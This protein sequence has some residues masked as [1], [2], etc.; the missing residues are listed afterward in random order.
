VKGRGQEGVRV[1]DAGR[2]EEEMKRTF[3]PNF[4][5]GETTCHSAGMDP[6]KVFHSGHV[7]ACRLDAFLPSRGP[8]HVAV[9]GHLLD[10]NNDGCGYRLQHGQK[11]VKACRQH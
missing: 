9:R 10:V 8:L 4:C 1:R 3:S 2:Q 7:L 6:Q 5:E 11:E